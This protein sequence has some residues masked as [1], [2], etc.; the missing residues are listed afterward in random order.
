MSI[1]T[2]EFRKLRNQ[3][4]NSTQSSLLPRNCGINCLEGWNMAYLN[5]SQSSVDFGLE[6]AENGIPF[7]LLVSEHVTDGPS[8]MYKVL[9]NYLLQKPRSTV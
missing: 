4:R 7:G 1:F 8:D 3:E 5:G 2:G 9:K 6:Y